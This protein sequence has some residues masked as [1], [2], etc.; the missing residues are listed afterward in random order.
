MTSK[1]GRDIREELSWRS[2]LYDASHF[3]HELVPF[4]CLCFN[5]DSYDSP[6]I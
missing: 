1:T 3:L 2:V 4:Y 6:K 5:D